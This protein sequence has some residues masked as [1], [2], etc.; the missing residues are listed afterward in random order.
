MLYFPFQQSTSTRPENVAQVYQ[1]PNISSN[2]KTAFSKHAKVD[3]YYYR[4]GVQTHME[5]SS[6]YAS[7]RSVNDGQRQSQTNPAGYHTRSVSVPRRMY[8][9]NA[10][11]ADG[12]DVGVLPNDSRITKVH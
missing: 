9:D 5:Q 7:V 1:Q 8:D 11:S 4:P 3:D 2:V 6:R 12:P 10:Q